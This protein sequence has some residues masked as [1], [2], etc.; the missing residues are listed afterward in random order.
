MTTVSPAPRPS[1]EQRAGRRRWLLPVGILVGCFCVYALTISRGHNLSP[2]VWIA[3]FGSW[4]LAHT[5]NPWIEGIS[6]PGFDHNPLR[7]DWIV[8]VNGHSVVGRTPGVIAA[9]VPAYLLFRPAHMTTVPGGLTAALL[10]ACAVV[11]MYDAL[12]RKMER[13]DA[14]LTA[15]AFGFATPVWSIAAN[16]MWP[17]TVT[18]LGIAGMVW[19]ATTDRWWL[20]GI[21]GGVTLWGRLH[22][23]VI[24]AV[25]GLLVGWRRRDAMIVVRVGVAS[26]A[27]LVAMSFWT[28]WMYGS[29]NPTASYDAGAFADY[30]KENPFNL[31][32]QAGMW[33]SPA[34]G[35]FV[36]TPVALLLLPAL[37]RAWGNLPDWSRALI[38]GGLV[39]TVLQAML[40]RFSGG[41][42]SYGYRLTLEM[43]ACSTPALALSVRY[44][45]PWARRL[46]G[47]LLALQTV[48]IA[49]GAVTDKF[50]VGD[51]GRWRENPFVLVL[52]QIGVGSVLFVALTLGVGALAGRI[53]GRTGA[54]LPDRQPAGNVSS[55]S[56]P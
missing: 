23:A 1:T 17:H 10:M 9:A 8:D 37:V 39:Y 45:G 12:R 26:G 42:F 30:A 43:L 18:V 44:A 52:E 2:D 33:V 28:H 29:W 3:D 54:P 4:H 11:L 51:A 16:G 21:F 36:W 49:T 41:D 34:R 46:L 35:F 53:W 20:V 32:N 25:L 56:V 7:H 48:A 14:L 22:A 47:P 15:L 38:Y 50:F 13:R 40:N 31:V 19:A 24:V 55:H 5:G 6:L 27:F